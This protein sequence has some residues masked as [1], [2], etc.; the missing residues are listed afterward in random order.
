MSIACFN[1]RLTTISSKFWRIVNYTFL[2]VCIGYTLAAL[3]L[4]VFKCDPPYASYDLIKIGDSGRVPKCLPVNDMNSVLRINLALDFVALAIPV[5][6]LWKVQLSW[7]KKA[8]LFAVLS[9]GLI[10]C[11]ASVMTLVSQYTL[12]TDPLWNYTTLLAWIMVEL[13]VSIIAACAPTLAY[14]LPKSMKSQ[15][16]TSNNA[17][18]TGGQ[19]N[20]GYNMGSR[21]S[22]NDFTARSRP[23]HSDDTS[24]EEDER[25]IIV[26]EDIEM[27]W[28]GGRDGSQAS[29]LAD[30]GS[31]TSWYNERDTKNGTNV[32]DGRDQERGMRTWV[33]TSELSSKRQAGQA[34]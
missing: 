9:I 23:M 15:R 13:V 28:Q 32:Y 22:K 25:R 16:A 18:K 7:R 1:I 27:K 2:A 10:A 20:S 29:D 30:S 11:I 3:F 31:L 19:Q 24:S 5:I 14:L 33:S 21:L 6:V 34:M 12:A 17:S 8:R 26:K 4:N